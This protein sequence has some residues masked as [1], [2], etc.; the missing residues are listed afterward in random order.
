MASNNVVSILEKDFKKHHILIVLSC[1]IVFVVIL[2][3]SIATD[4]IHTDSSLEKNVLPQD[5]SFIPSDMQTKLV[6][7][8]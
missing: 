3:V 2:L 5:Q 1:I 8:P 6:V 7:T 4:I